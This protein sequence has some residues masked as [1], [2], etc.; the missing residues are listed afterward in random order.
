MSETTT[1]R[2]NKKDRK[3][4]KDFAE[5]SGCSVVFLLHA[6]AETIK[7]GEVEFP[8]ILKVAIKGEKSNG[9]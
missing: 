2:I 7:K 9:E 6:F 3:V 1:I 8:A 5:K 4:I